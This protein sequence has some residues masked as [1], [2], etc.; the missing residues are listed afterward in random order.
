MDTV[1]FTVMFYVSTLSCIF[2]V[3][4]L[5][6]QRDIFVFSFIDDVKFLQSKHY[7]QTEMYI[8]QNYS[9]L[10]DVLCLN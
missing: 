9:K 10:N 2:K 1:K 6:K 5:I 3:W 4:C 7:N 8:F